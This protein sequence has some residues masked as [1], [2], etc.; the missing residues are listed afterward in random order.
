MLFGDY[1][2]GV[3]TVLDRHPAMAELATHFHGALALGLHAFQT[4]PF[5]LAL[6]GVALAWYFYLV[7]PAIPAAI[8]ARFRSLHALLDNKYYL[9]R[10]NE[11]VFAGGSRLLGRTLWKRGDQELIDGV[12]VN[13]SA[14][15]VGAVA[16]VVRG[17]Q[18]GRINT[19]AITMIVGIALLL[20]YAVLPL[21]NR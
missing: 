14:R 20:L 12:V 16:A 3:I 6:A 9:D 5:V 7:N 10:F 21:L 2:K 19:Y 17:V 13:G 8:Q 11:V 1:F 15:L 18:T 4:L